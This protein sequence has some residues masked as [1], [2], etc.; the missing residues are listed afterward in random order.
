MVE[1]VLHILLRGG[2]GDPKPFL[3]TLKI[4]NDKVQKTD[5][6]VNKAQYTVYS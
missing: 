5:N 6:E 4:F 1:R 2:K 3:A